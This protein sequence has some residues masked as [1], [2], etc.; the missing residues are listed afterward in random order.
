MPE[1]DTIAR[2]AV[3][4]RRWL[5]GREVTAARGGPLGPD[6]SVLVGATLDQVEARAK[7]LLMHFSTGLVLH[8]HMRMTGSWYVHPTG[9][10]W[11]KPAYQ[12]VAVIESGERLAVC[13]NAPVVELVAAR[14]LA[15]HDALRRLGPDVLH[16]R[17]PTGD[18]LAGRAAARAEQAPTV[19]EL[20]LDQQVVSGIGNVYRCE[21]LFLCGVHP[22]TPTATL[23]PTTLE[24]LVATAARVMAA[25]AATS[26]YDR[27][28]DAG[29]SRPWVYGRA[30]RPCRRC[31]TRIASGRL[32]AEARVVYW[33]PRCQPPPAGAG[34]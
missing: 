11:R 33:C 16:D 5:G 10:R 17:L 19:G 24:R 25:N 1:G 6:L 21:T 26:A 4:L 12:A 15:L 8:T 14:D 34:H 27:A 28:F 22:W 20:L 31:R 3:S 32:G 23:D 29:P 30:G 9:Q 2:A 13:F 18:E 7:H